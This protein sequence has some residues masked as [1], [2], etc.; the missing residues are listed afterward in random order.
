M[1]EDDPRVIIDEK[2]ERR[3]LPANEKVSLV[4]TDSDVD[5]AEVGDGIEEKVRVL[6]IA[7][8]KMVTLVFEFD[9]VKGFWW[10]IPWNF[11]EALFLNGR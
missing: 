9:S 11:V 3:A 4:G 1:G 8:Q 7:V 6:F 10:R 2:C 5:A